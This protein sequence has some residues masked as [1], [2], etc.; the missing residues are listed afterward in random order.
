[1]EQIRIRLRPKE[2]IREAS[3]A[4]SSDTPDTAES[5]C[6]SDGDFK[7][8]CEGTEGATF[9]VEL[10]RCWSPFLSLQWTA[11]VDDEEVGG[12]MNYMPGWH[13]DMV[14]LSTGSLLYIEY[15]VAKPEGTEDW[16]A[17][18][19]APHVQFREVVAAKVVMEKAQ[20]SE[21][22][23]PVVT[24]LIA[25]ANLSVGNSGETLC[26]MEIVTIVSAAL[27]VVAFGVVSA[28][29]ILLCLG[30][31]RAGGADTNKELDSEE[32]RKRQD[33]MLS[34][35]GKRSYLSPATEAQRSS[36]TMQMFDHSSSLQMEEGAGGKRRSKARDSDDEGDDQTWPSEQPA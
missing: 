6:N 27:F 24:P 12:T 16:S 35:P 23:F 29:L 11:K 32:A 13:R 33:E 8:D 26:A 14:Q 7:V 2:R 30:R 25:K 20:G 18:Q 4:E 31:G 17:D 28:F 19:K 34:E 36:T 22:T 3:A 15:T 10:F 5:S 21:V 9:G 1:M